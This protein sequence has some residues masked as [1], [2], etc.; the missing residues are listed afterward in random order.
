MESKKINGGLQFCVLSVLLGIMFSCGLKYEIHRN[1]PKE[2]KL[3][4]VIVYDTII[5]K[6]RSDSLK[7][8][9]KLESVVYYNKG[10]TT[11]YIIKAHTKKFIIRLDSLSRV[12]KWSRYIELY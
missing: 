8:P 2:A 12:V 4:H 3:N 9:Y 11:E 5:N 10:N 6:I 7:G 1:M